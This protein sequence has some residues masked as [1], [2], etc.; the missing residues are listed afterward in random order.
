MSRVRWHCRPGLGRWLKSELASFRA[1]AI[2]ETTFEA[3]TQACIDDIAR[4]RIALHFGFELPV[5]D[6]ETNATTQSRVRALVSAVASPE[7]RG[8]FLGLTKTK[9]DRIRYRIEWEGLGHQRAATRDAV[10]LID[11]KCPFLLNDPTDTTWQIIATC[12]DDTL[13]DVELRPNR[14][15]DTRFSYRVEE[16]QGASHPTISAALARVAGVRADDVVWDP[17]VGAGTELIER[18]MAGPYRS[19]YG[20]DIDPKAVFAA[21]SCLRVANIHATIV[22][23]DF[24]QCR[25][26]EPVSLVI[27]NPPMGHRVLEKNDLEPLFEDFF[28]HMRESL[29]RDGR[30]VMLS[31]LPRQTAAMGESH[32]MNVI[33]QTRL[34]VANVLAELQVFSARRRSR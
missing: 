3:K 16:V 10:A 34:E 17:F 26:P 13:I 24:R 1:K 20:S 27:T 28:A 18:A 25:P 23:S 6:A 31:P 14:W 19:L 30:I 21:Q 5:A 4:P 32:G 29:R 9:K 12:H 33:R 8:I 2:S 22:V 11:D 15:T 7:A